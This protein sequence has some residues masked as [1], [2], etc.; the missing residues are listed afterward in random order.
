M[1]LLISL[2]LDQLFYLW[3]TSISSKRKISYC[4]TR[5]NNKI[6]LKKKEKL[7]NVFNFITDCLVERSCLASDILINR[8]NKIIRSIK[9]YFKMVWFHRRC[10]DGYSYLTR[11]H[12]LFVDVC[13]RE[14]TTLHVNIRFRWR[15]WSFFSLNIKQTKAIHI[16]RKFW[17]K[18]VDLFN[19]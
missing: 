4:F 18:I 6:N 11:W 7:K 10:C 16:S 8:K 12:I 2:R 17:W 5:F 15:S 14:S 1:L 19:Q 9:S 3:S 13:R